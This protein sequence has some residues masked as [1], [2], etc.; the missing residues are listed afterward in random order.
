MPD[1]RE[2]RWL[3]DDEC[4]RGPS[5]GPLRS[6]L[7]AIVDEYCQLVSEGKRVLEIGCG[8][9][10]PVR[11]RCEEVGAVWEGIDVN[12]THMGR[13]TIATKI[14]SVADIPFGDAEFD[15]VVANQSMEHWR[16]YSVPLERGLYEAFRVTRIGGQVLLNVPI[17]LHGAP[18]FVKGEIQKIRQAIEAFSPDVHLETWRA[19]PAPLPPLRPHLPLYVGHP[20]LWRKSAHILDIRATRGSAPLAHVPNATIP[21]FRRQIEG[22]RERGALYYLMLAGVMVRTKVRR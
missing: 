17:H 21:A 1:C 5:H 7:Q 15:L 12:D 20:R 14:A 6:C 8:A 13:P 11:D 10:S 18:M 3:V 16:E 9:W 4:R 2:C 19:R 22:L